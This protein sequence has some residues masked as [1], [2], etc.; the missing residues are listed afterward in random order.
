MNL[1][2]LKINKM[3]IIKKILELG[4]ICYK[5]QVVLVNLIFI[6]MEIIQQLL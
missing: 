5:I 4:K 1:I 2:D 6:D 3:E